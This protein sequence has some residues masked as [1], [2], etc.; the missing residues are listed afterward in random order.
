[1][2]GCAESDTKKKQHI[3]DHEDNLRKQ[4]IAAYKA[5]LLKPETKR[6]S[7][8]AVARDFVNLYRK[9]T[10]R[11]IKMHHTFLTRKTEGSSRTRAEANAARSWLLDDERDVVIKYIGECGARGFLLS[12]HRL[13]EHVNEILQARLGV[14]FPLAGVGKKWSH[15]FVEKYSDQIKMSWSTPLESKRGRAV[16]EHM[17]K[18]WFDLVEE[19]TTKYSIMPE[20]TYGVDEVGT[21][22]FN[23]EKEWVMGARQAAPQYQQWDGNRENITVLVTI[24]ADGTTP[25]PAAIFKGRSFQTKWKQDNPADAA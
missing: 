23:G 16:N 9:E 14:K 6:K 5:E 4:A 11:E 13:Q 24:C 20:T 22:P 10:G 3:H 7:A 19:V 18:A 2:V 21:N 25:P 1:M 15:R 17:A 12:H 8:R